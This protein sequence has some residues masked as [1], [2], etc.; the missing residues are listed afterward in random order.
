MVWP[1]RALEFRLRCR[2]WQDRSTTH[3]YT[4]LDRLEGCGQSPP[5]SAVSAASLR[6]GT[7]GRRPRLENILVAGDNLHALKAL[8]PYYAGKVKCN[9]I[10]LPYNTGS[11]DWLYNVNGPEIRD[12]LDKVV[13]FAVQWRAWRQTASE[14]K[15]ADTGDSWVSA[16][17]RWSAGVIWC[18]AP[19]RRRKAGESWRDVYAGAL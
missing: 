18:G 6:T 7:F 9:F 12:W 19:T 16:A 5:R 11:E 14:R 15:C 8:L 4:G 3:A 17:S 13:G 1:I 10:D 2:A